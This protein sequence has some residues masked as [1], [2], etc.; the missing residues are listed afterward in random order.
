MNRIDR[1]EIYRWFNLFVAWKAEP[2]VEIRIVGNG[3]SASGY[4]S[5]PDSII[6]WVERY[7]TR[8]IYFTINSIKSQIKGR[9]QYN[10]IIEHPGATT[11]DK[12]IRS[13]DWVF[14]DIDVDRE[15]DINATEDETLQAKAVARKVVR[16]LTEQGINRPIVIFSGNGV[17]L[18][19]RCQL[20]NSDV[21]TKA[22]KDLIDALRLMFDD[23]SIKIDPVVYNASRIARLPG[24]MSG[25]GRSDDTE[26][27]QRMCRILSVPTVISPNDIAYF[28]KIGSIVEPPP[29]PNRV[30]NWGRDKFDLQDFLRKHNI[31]VKQEVRVSDGV[32]YILDHCV[33]D[34]NHKGKDAMIFQ[35]NNGALVYK[36]FH[37]SCSQYRWR[38]VRLLYEPDAYSSREDFSDFAYKRRMRGQDKPEPFVP[39][40]ET[41]EK[42]PIW[43]GLDEIPTIDPDAIE[44]IG[45]GIRELDDKMMGGTILQQLSIMTGRPASGKSTLLNTVMLN[46]IQQGYPTAIFSGELPN[47][48]LKSW[49]TLPAAGRNNVRLSMKRDAYYVPKDIEGKILSWLKGRLFVHNSEYGNNWKQLRD[50]ILKIIDRGAKNIILD[51]LMTLY[52]GNEDDRSRFKAQIDFIWEL[53]SLAQDKNV[54]VWLVAHPKKQSNF[55]RFEDISGASEIGNLADNIFLVHRV[56]QDF[57]NQAKNFFSTSKVAEITMKGYTNVVEIGKNR[58]PGLYV[59]DLVGM[60]YEPESKRMKNDKAEM[61]QYGWDTTPAQQGLPLDNLHAETEDLWYN[62]EQDN[63]INF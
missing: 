11:T 59:G 18:Y 39:Q 35:H 34:S 38:D 26:R 51:N 57:E 25:K 24:T 6:E 20:L 31:E 22:V 46:S 10:K 58:L 33:F 4:F 53:H 55:L 48:L 3:Y 13:R 27:P 19:F 5:D 43:L 41:A 9:S 32:R 56:G 29:A 2:L 15:K 45:T 44:S 60:Y 63:E 21:S 47:Q 12:E 49:I 52:L 54:H 36:C 14:L 62:K 23:E 16:Y 42:G 37:A 7:D 50:D 30:N 1:G 8:N 17:H 40:Q 61:F 28:E